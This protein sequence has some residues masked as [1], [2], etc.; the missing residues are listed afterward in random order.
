[1]FGV[2][3]IPADI[4]ICQSLDG[5]QPSSFY[6]VFYDFLEMAEASKVLTGFAV[7]EDRSLSG[8]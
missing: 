2:A 3:K 6:P 7:F 1:M 8:C 5:I 4:C